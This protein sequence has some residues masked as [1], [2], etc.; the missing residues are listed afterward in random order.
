MLG[1]G[2]MCVVDDESAREQEK[3]VVVNCRW[4]SPLRCLSRPQTAWRRPGVART[5]GACR[6]QNLGPAPR[7]GNRPADDPFVIMRS[8]N[9][10]E[11]AIQARWRIGAE[12]ERDAMFPSDQ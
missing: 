2:E 11:P 8:A 10:S 7:D 4:S 12:V 1:G 9:E 3:Q 5:R 6:S